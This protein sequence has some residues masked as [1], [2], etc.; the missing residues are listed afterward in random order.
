MVHTAVADGRQDKPGS[1]DHP[2][3]SRFPGSVINEYSV[4][5]FDQIK[6]PVKLFTRDDNQKPSDDK[7]VAVEGRITSLNYSLPNGTSV[8][9][10]TRSYEAALTQKGFQILFRCH[11]GSDADGSSCISVGGYVVNSGNAMKPS[12]GAAY[13]S[14]DN[15]YLLAKRASPQG[16]VYVMV[17]GMENSTHPVA[18][19]LQIVEEAP[20]KADQIVVA[21]AAA[22]QASLN[23]AGRAAVYGIYFDTGQA[24]VK[25]ESKPALDEMGKLLRANPRLNVY[26]VGHTDNQGTLAGNLELSQRRAQAVADTLVREARID[27]GRLGAKGLASL[28]PVASNAQEAGRAL[29][30]RVEMVVQ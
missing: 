14:D 30:R 20:M 19:D 17:Y 4:R 6:L 3:V 24:V 21:D 2:L 28:A 29:N 8:L 7:I 12:F 13:F 16:N 5:T 11:S 22:L 15:R 1:Q 26:I 27:A 25:P 23:E 10:A 9:E 18:V